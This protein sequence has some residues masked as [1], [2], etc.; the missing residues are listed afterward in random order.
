MNC[1]ITFK[2]LLVCSFLLMLGISSSSAQ[3]VSKGNKPILEIVTPGVT[4]MPELEQSLV[5]RGCEYTADTNAKSGEYE[6]G[7]DAECFDLPG[8]PVV[9][10]GSKDQEGLVFQI[11]IPI[12]GSL[13]DFSR[14]R[15]ALE[16]IYGKPTEEGEKEES[17]II[18]WEFPKTPLLI[19][20]SKSVES[21]SSTLKPLGLLTYLM[22]KEATKDI[23]R[24]ERALTPRTGK[25]LGNL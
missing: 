3:E 17:E 16:K 8:D 10:I 2:T 9:K 14:Y 15:T 21:S 19:V 24:V 25:D 18:S 7:I 20:L 13:E 12:Y 5:D 23:K 22:G 1:K 11:E 6:I 4:T